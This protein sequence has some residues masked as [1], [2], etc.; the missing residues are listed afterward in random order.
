[1]TIPTTPAAAQTAAP[2]LAATLAGDELDLLMR[3]AEGAR[4]IVEFGA[5]HST[6][7]FA[8]LGVP[9][10]ISVDSDP[11]WI[12]RLRLDPA[13]AEAEASGRLTLLHADIGPVK[14]WGKPR[15]RSVPQPSWAGYALLPWHTVPEAVPDLVFVD[16]R[17]RLACLYTALYFAPAG[18]PILIHDFWNRPHYHQALDFTAVTARTGT[19]AALTARPDLD[20]RALASALRSAFRDWR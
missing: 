7:A 18:T 4:C 17:F 10:L 14:N 12:G 2:L 11:D 5:G 8:R 9:R 6:G 15:Q 19:M 3:H 13:V 1:M 20:L 16:G